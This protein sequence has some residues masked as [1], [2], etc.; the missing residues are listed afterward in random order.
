MVDDLFTGDAQ[1]PPAT[2]NPSSS[3]GKKRNNEHAALSGSDDELERM[4]DLGDSSDE[5]EVN[6]STPSRPTVPDPSSPSSP[7]LIILKRTGAG[8]ADRVQLQNGVWVTNYEY[9]R[10]CNIASNRRKMRELGI[11]FTKTND[12]ARIPHKSIK[13]QRQG[14]AIPP[15]FPPTRAAK[16]QLKS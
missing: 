7:S 13:P 3:R 16:Q 10:L 9:A 11:P 12:P 6:E 5:E 2:N 14:H 1:S 15:R 8:E 4:S